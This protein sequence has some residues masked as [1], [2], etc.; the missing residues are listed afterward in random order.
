MPTCLRP[1]RRGVRDTRLAGLGNVGFE[2][3]TIRHGELKLMYHIGP[4]LL[5]PLWFSSE[6]LPLNLE[7][8]F[9]PGG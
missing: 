8:F 2:Q 1:I 9:S 5:H 7:P 3:E 4:L 6:S